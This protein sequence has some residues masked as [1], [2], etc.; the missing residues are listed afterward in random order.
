MGRWAIGLLALTLVALGGLL[1]SRWQESLRWKLATAMH[2][3]FVA[4]DVAAME[5][6]YDW[7]DVDAATRARVRLIILQEF[8]LPV[9]E[10]APLPTPPRIFRPWSTSARTWYRPASSVSST[11]PRTAF[12]PNSSS[13]RPDSRSIA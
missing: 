10:V 11:T 13:E 4:R 8:E 7:T 5:R 3:A 12:P 9:L 2:Q 6:L 1:G